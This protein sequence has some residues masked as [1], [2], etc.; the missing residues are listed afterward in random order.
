MPFNRPIPES[1]PRGKSASALASLIEAEKMMQI[2][3]LL[4]AAAFV[5]WVAGAG[6]DYLLHQTWITVVGIIF[7]GVSGLVYVVRMV[8]A[9]GVKSAGAGNGKSAE[10]GKGSSEIKP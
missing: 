1:K 6:L 9:T 8:M 4:P 5:G 2:A 10:T 7:G 3:I